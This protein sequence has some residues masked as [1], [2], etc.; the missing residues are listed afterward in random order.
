MRQSIRVAGRDH[1]GTSLRIPD[2]VISLAN[3]WH[4]RD[5]LWNMTVRH[6]R[7]QYKQSV[8]GYAWAFINPLSQM[9]I[10]SFVFSRSSASPSGVPVR[11]LFLFVGLIP[12]NSSRARSQQVQIGSERLQPGHQSVFP[13]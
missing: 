4:R 1:I 10:L 6:L 7:G 9:I 13:A 3:L 2:F 12:W 11:R 8:L 5:L